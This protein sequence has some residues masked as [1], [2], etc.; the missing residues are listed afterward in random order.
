MG[1]RRGIVS[2]RDAKKHVTWHVVCVQGF[3][4]LSALKSNSSMGRA[5]PELVERG[6]MGVAA[7]GAGR[8]GKGVEDGTFFF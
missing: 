1:I 2:A 6:A 7:V 5:M 4:M 3:K 8:V